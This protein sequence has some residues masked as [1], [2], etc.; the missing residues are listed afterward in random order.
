MKTPLFFRAFVLL[1]APVLATQLAVAQQQDQTVYTY[2][3]QFRVPAAKRGDFAFQ[4]NQYAKPV[5]DRLLADGA[6]LNWGRSAPVV[7]TANGM[8]DTVWWCAN[9]VSGA[10]KV[11]EEVAKAK[12]P[13]SVAEAHQDALLQSMI[14]K[15]RESSATSGYLYVSDWTF[16]TG[17]AGAWMDAFDKY[18]KPVYEGLLASGDI[19][20]YGVNFEFV[21]TADPRSRSVWVLVENAE[22][23]DKVT[24]AMAAARSVRTPSER[25]AFEQTNAEILV[26]DAHRDSLDTVVEFH[27]K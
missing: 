25:T 4:F 24:A 21:H 12:M 18:D 26:P 5:L 1:L 11:L 22:S 6:I 16:Q 19:L 7:H 2:V 17:K 15:T 10:V 14:F 9:Q 13:P 23:A 20:G 3:S 8:T 27:H